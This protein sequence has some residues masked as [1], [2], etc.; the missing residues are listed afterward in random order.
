MA[1]YLHAYTL[2]SITIV[3]VLTVM[4]SIKMM[5]MKPKNAVLSGVLSVF[6]PAPS[7]THSSPYPPIKDCAKLELSINRQRKFGEKK[8]VV[9]LV[10]IPF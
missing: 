3:L 5:K 9:L 6:L 7:T 1:T 10:K 2:I 4:A 8:L